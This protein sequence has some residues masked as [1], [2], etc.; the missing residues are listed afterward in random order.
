MN[1]KGNDPLW[2]EVRS[3]QVYKTLKDVGLP[4]AG[5]LADGLGKAAQGLDQA[6]NSPGSSRPD[7][8]Y[9]PSGGPQ[10]GGPQPGG[11]QQPGSTGPTV[12]QPTGQQTRS[13]QGNG[14]QQ[15]G[16]QTAGPAANGYYHYSYPQG[17]QT[18][19]PQPQQTRPPQAPLSRRGRPSA[20]PQPIG[21][22]QPDKQRGSRLRPP[23]R[24]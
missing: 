5:K 7:H 24:R 23:G 2:E 10:P 4:L 15:A 12:Q 13:S 1:Q 18:R 14:S 19:P 9:R 3:S 22:R 21:Q 8:P 16:G 6:I 11:P 17:Q 20:R